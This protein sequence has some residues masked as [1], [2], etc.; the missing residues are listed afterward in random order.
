[1]QELITR[2][3]DLWTSA[4]QIK[5]TAGRG[6]SGDME[7]YGIQK[8]R[9]L[10]LDLAV[11][12][13]L[14]SHDPNDEPAQSLVD[15][16]EKRKLELIKHGLLKKQA[17]LPPIAENDVAILLPE[18]WTV[19]RL[20]DVTNYGQTEK[21]EHSDV[22][23][24]MWVLDL[25]DVEK[26][27][28]KL[29]VKT[30]FKEKPFLSSKN[31][32]SVGDVIYGKLRPYLDKVLV[33][34]EPGVCTTEMI[35]FNGFGLLDPE[36]LR[37]VLKTRRF[38]QHAN[39]S[40]HGMSLPRVGTEAVRMAPIP[41]APYTE[42]KRIV[43]KVNELMTLCDQLEQQQ[44][45]SLKAH[46]AL[47]A[48]LLDTL[49]RAESAT[50]FQQAWQRIATHFDTLFTTEHSIDQLKQTIL[51]LAVTGKLV[52]QSPTTGF[53]YEFYGERIDIPKIYVRSKKQAIKGKSP[54]AVASLPRI[55]DTWLYKSVDELYESGHILDYADGNHGSLYP[56]KEDFGD[57]GVLF[58]TAAQFDVNGKID[59]KTCP[60]LRT[61]VAEKLT[62]GWS[63]SGDVYFTHNATVGKT[64][65]AQYSDDDEWLLG[66]SVTYYR[67][68]GNS[69]HAPY[70]YLY[71][72]SASWLL[73]ADA[74]MQ[75]TTRNQV[76][77][78]K[79][80][81]FYIALPPP[82]E[83]V[84]ITNLVLELFELMEQ[85]HKR[86]QETESLRAFLAD[87]IVEQAVA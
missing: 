2:N 1:M 80:A 87:A 72:T 5:S 65:I 51:Q 18:S 75:Q 84:R 15:K 62:K 12:G 86:I 47:V 63:R 61:E 24:K 53:A 25:E 50:D 78:T 74:V 76:S 45:T 42:Q 22:H 59:W 66:T 82:A 57:E 81:L 48:T 30:R 55:P 31:R 14:T 9:S 6:N 44:D 49:T 46:Q 34:D 79:Q 85:L 38:I 56:R 54:L 68:N 58:L 8:L 69:I 60:R 35:P 4:V 13:R 52:E 32:F 28:S 26:G 7:A 23:D 41:I 27:T 39:E 11:S 73:Q 77:I 16:I 29:L 64:G 21:V 43:T 71:L 20:G 67:I 36:F 3:L 70:L 33:A 37:L 40:T 83:Q 10:V 19:T 17:Q